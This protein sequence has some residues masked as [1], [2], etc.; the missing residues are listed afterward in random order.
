M[1]QQTISLMIVL[2]PHEP[3]ST[4]L[5]KIGCVLPSLLN[6]TVDKISKVKHMKCVH[7]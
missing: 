6:I 3:I 4:L 2:L 1:I 5:S 7:C